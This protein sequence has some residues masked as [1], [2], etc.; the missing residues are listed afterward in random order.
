M[1]TGIGIL[2]PPAK[3]GKFAGII[4]QS[5]GVRRS[6]TL[7]FQYGAVSLVKEGVCLDEWERH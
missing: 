7:V 4:P 3:P 1:W 2:A 6:K 5:H